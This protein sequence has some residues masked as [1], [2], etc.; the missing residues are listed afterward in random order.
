MKTLL[1]TGATREM[2]DVLN[3][4]RLSKI[5]Y[6]RDKGYVFKSITLGYQRPIFG[7]RLG[8][9]RMLEAFRHIGEYDA[10]IWLDADAFITNFNYEVNDF[11]GSDKPFSSSLD[12]TE[13]STV[14]TGNFVIYNTKECETLHKKF[15]VIGS[16]KFLNDPQQEQRTINY[17]LETTPELIHVLPRKY[18]N[19]VPEIAK[20]YRQGE[21]REIAEPWDETCFLAHLTTIPNQYRVEIMEKNL[22]GLEKKY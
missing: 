15:V 14:S 7:V 10:V 22:L 19:A 21:E 4:S 1:L 20:K 13:C 6:C 16:E 3:A 2:S 9:E 8:F 5:E 17:I 11:R 12:W 18:L